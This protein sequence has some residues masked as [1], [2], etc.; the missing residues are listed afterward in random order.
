[1]VT[2][3]LLHGLSLSEN[4]DDLTDWFN[5]RSNALHNCV[6][7]SFCPLGNTNINVRT[8]VNLARSSPVRSNIIHFVYLETYKIRPFYG[9]TFYG[10]HFMDAHFTELRNTWEKSKN[11]EKIVT[12]FSDYRSLVK[13]E[14]VLRFT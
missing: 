12:L 3:I 8:L 9:H 5:N 6:C 1:M 13:T 11:R 4:I 14:N 7:N 10:I 2:Y